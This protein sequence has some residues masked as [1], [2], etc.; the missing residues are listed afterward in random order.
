M[1]SSTTSRQVAI[2]QDAA[3]VIVLDVDSLHWRDFGDVV[4]AAE[5]TVQFTSG[6]TVGQ[7]LG[8][9]RK[10][11]QVD[12]LSKIEWVP[13]ASTLIVRYAWWRDPW[14][15]KFVADSTGEAIFEKVGR[16]LSPSTGPMS[17][18]VGAN[19]LAMDPKLALL[20]MLVV[21]GIIVFVGGALEGPAQAPV[22]G[23]L[24]KFASLAEIGA[25]LGPNVAMLL[26]GLVVLGGIAALV[27]W[28]LRRPTKLVYQ[29]FQ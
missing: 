18:R 19:D 14:W 7:A 25:R 22:V 2:W 29:R 15:I 27:H 11:L 20:V 5:A 3:S 21:V 28:S 1:S 17:K 26:G 4:A 13:A 16:R 23:P 9:A 12:R 6:A 24:A 8:R 10:Q